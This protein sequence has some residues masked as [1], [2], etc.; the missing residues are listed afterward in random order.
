MKIRL[1]YA[2]GFL[3]NNYA[4]H[5]RTVS[6]HNNFLVIEDLEVY[7]SADYLGTQLTSEGFF[8]IDSE[9]YVNF[10][11]VKPIIDENTR[12]TLG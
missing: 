11:R 3:T 7:Q 6:C 5:W 2:T 12:F 9:G 4:G 8:E 1:D 10:M